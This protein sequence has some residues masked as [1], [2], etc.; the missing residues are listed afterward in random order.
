MDIYEKMKLQIISLEKELEKPARKTDSKQLDQ[1][2][3]EKSDLEK[4]ALSEDLAKV[5]LR[6]AKAKKIMGEHKTF[7]SY[8]KDKFNQHL[9]AAEEYLKNGKFYRAADAYT[10]AS[11]YKP[12]DPLPYAGKSHA[13]FA[14]GEYMSS[15]LFLNRALR[16]FP[17][18][19]NFKIDLVAML[20][21][22][23]KLES[24]IVDV[25]EWIKKSDAAEL[26]FLIA[27]VYH[28]LTRPDKAIDS[29]RMAHEKM[30]DDP[31]VATLK[32]V[33]ENAR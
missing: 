21:D 20:K 30:P 1:A 6:A 5:S 16:M 10:L 4:K 9:R 15:S 17:E 27:Y 18:Y 31:A 22:R 29:V 25:E 33:I 24:R 26:H 11:I 14:A 32:N 28:Q 19:A 13:L 12:Q 2:D 23:D 3:I 7:A 8:S